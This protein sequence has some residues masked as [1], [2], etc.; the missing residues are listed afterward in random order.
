ME[1]VKRKT[2]KNK[3]IR[4]ELCTYIFWMVITHFILFLYIKIL[5][6]IR[7]TICPF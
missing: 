6:L 3:F 1:V 5:N 4:Q 2:N 7:V